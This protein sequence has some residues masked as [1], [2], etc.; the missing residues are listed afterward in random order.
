MLDNVSKFVDDR[1][2]STILHTNPFPYLYI[3]DFFPDDFYSKLEFIFPDKKY[4]TNINDKSFK[5][6]DPRAVPVHSRSTLTIFNREVGYTEIE[7]YPYKEQ[8][9][10]FRQW[11]H[12]YLI[13]QLALKL[14]LGLSKWDDDTRFVLDQPGYEKRPHTDHPQKIFS[15]LIYMSDSAC[16]TT[17]LKPKQDGFS[18]DYGYDHKFE[19][20]EEVFDP[21]F[22]PNSIIAFPR[23]D[24][25]FHCVKMLDE[26]EYRRAIHINIRS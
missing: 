3:S 5:P 7:E 13:P 12:N 22:K 24:T 10:Q 9:I 25:S 14:Q 11:A 20:F 16:G 21:P 15:I 26:G 8:C 18:D 19:Q 2:Q 6:L 17:L 4:L 23:T 1:L